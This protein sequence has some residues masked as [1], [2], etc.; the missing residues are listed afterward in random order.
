LDLT[1]GSLG[2]LNVFTGSQ[3]NISDQAAI[4]V[5]TLRINDS[6]TTAAFNNATVTTG[7]LSLYKGSTATAAQGTQLNGLSRVDVIEGSTLT[8][9]GAGTQM[10]VGNI[11][12]GGAGS[13]L[14]IES[15]ATVNA[16]DGRILEG[17]LAVNNGTLNMTGT[18]RSGE[19]GTPSGTLA[20]SNNAQL[21]VGGDLFVEATLTGQDSTLTVD[22]RLAVTDG[23]V[24]LTGSS[25]SIRSLEFGGNSTLNLTDTQLTIQ[26]GASVSGGTLTQSGGATVFG[27]EVTF[28]DGAAV[29]VTGGGS[30]A[31][32]DLGDSDN[33]GQI[34]VTNGS[35]FSLSGT[36]TTLDLTSGSLGDL[37][38]FTG[39]QL[40]VS[41][42]AT[43][44]V[45]AM[46]VGGTGSTATFNHSTLTAESLDLTDG[47]IF[48]ATLSA[49]DITGNTT[50]ID[51]TS[52]MVLNG[53]TYDEAGD[54]IVNGQL[55]GTNPVI[56]IGSDLI[57]NNGGSVGFSGL[58]SLLIGDDLLFFDNPGTLN[59]GSTT[60]TMQGSLDDDGDGLF[61][62]NL[63]SA[64][65]SFLDL[66]KLIVGAVDLI[67]KG[68]FNIGEL[69][70]PE[71]AEI[72]LADNSVLTVNRFTGNENSIT[73]DGKF[74]NNTP[75][76][77]E[78]TTLLL[79]GMG[80]LGLLGFRRF[81]KIG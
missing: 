32:Q 2:D 71:G 57:I 70:L 48:T 64:F 67:L 39:S 66:G 54:F 79:F 19:A 13:R 72:L 9:Q 37:N 22:Q 36:G 3:L 28:T 12:V 63:G 40:N 46:R 53:G 27:D 10:D 75:A 60:I 8:L 55:T 34:F 43:V 24:T 20:L 52:Q 50:T 45:N 11:E 21:K 74:I 44:N 23:Q 38:V 68:N 33:R 17:E 5:N 15:G 25:A 7:V 59:L 41:D 16:T 31:H 80:L 78:P 30:V 35:S 65:S 81:R 47:A 49:I 73:G 1:S 58:A 51:A 26:D 29:T 56:D 61:Q 77:P 42:Q 14:S 76:V 69:I 6:G 4:Q 62:F 18:L